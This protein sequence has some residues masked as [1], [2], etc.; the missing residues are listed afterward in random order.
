MRNALDHFHWFV[1]IEAP[2]HRIFF[3]RELTINGLLVCEDIALKT[4]STLLLLTVKLLIGVVKLTLL[5]WVDRRMLLL[6]EVSSTAE[7]TPL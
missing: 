2:C 3:A 1:K 7:T 5:L 6:V 4:K